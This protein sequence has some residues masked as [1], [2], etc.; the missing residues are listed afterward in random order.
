MPDTSVQLSAELVINEAAFNQAV[1]R[2]NRKPFRIEMEDRFSGPLGRVTGQTDKF[3]RAITAATDRVVAFGAAASAFY[4]V[5]RAISAL[6]RSTIDVEQSLARININLGESQS[7]LKTFERQL[8]SV[9]RNTGQTF[10]AAAAGAEELARQGLG[11][12]ET[13]KRLSDALILSR[14]TGQGVAETVE[15]ITASINS[16]NKEALTSTEVINK[17]AAVDQRF[18]VSA[19]DLADGISR[20]GSTAA[21]AGVQFDELVG[22]ITAV[23]QTTQRGGAVIGNSFKTFFAKLADKTALDNLEAIGIGVRNL[24]GEALPAT[25]ILENL[26]RSYD[27][28]SAAQKKVVNDT[29]GSLYQIN[30]LRAALSDL[31]KEYGVAARATAVA[32]AATDEAVRKNQQLNQTL[33]S[34]LNSVQQ[35]ITQ[36]FSSLGEIR[37]GPFID[38]LVRSF[39]G[40]AQ[41]LAGS[42]AGEQVGQSLGQSILQ[43]ISNV[44]TG[45]GLLLSLQVVAKTILAIGRTV[46]TEL[47]SFIKLGNLKETQAIT[48]NR[49]NTA[50]AKST[51]LEYGQFLAAKGVAE[52][53]A[54]ILRIIERINAEMALATVRQNA[55]RDSFV[56]SI[57]VRSTLFGQ[58][59]SKVPRAADGL[60]PTIRSEQSA[61]ARGVGGATPGSKAVVIPNFAFGGG[62][63][64][65]VVANTSEYI[66][67]NF[68]NGGSA[69]F[70]QDMVKAYGLPMGAKKL[71]KG[72]I[73]NF[74]ALRG[75]RKGSYTLGAGM[76]G[77]VLANK[78]RPDLVFKEF[79]GSNLSESGPG[80][81][82]YEYIVTKALE[83]AGFPVA[84]VYGSL[85]ASKRRGG[86]FKERIFGEEA[87]AGSAKSLSEL[88]KSL[89]FTAY[90]LVPRG[91]PTTANALTTKSGKSVVIDPGLFDLPDSLFDSIRASSRALGFIPN[92]ANPLVS[93][94][95]RE[96]AAGV[97]A[98]D[99]YVSQSPSLRAPGNPAG[100][101]VANTRDEPLGI[102]QGINRVL[103]QGGNP[104]VAGLMNGYVPNF[105]GPLLPNVPFNSNFQEVI[106]SLIGNRKQLRVFTGRGR[107]SRFA[108]EQTLEEIN[109][110][111]Q[112]YKAAVA[113]D[114]K[115]KKAIAQKEIRKLKLTGDSID[116]I[117]TV[118]EAYEKQ[119]RSDTKASLAIQKSI[120][121]NQQKESA[122]PGFV[123][124]SI[125]QKQREDAATTP[126]ITDNS[127]K[128]SATSLAEQEARLLESSTG[129]QRA[130]AEDT[131]RALAA[132][133]P[134]KTI[135]ALNRPITPEQEKENIRKVFRQGVVEDKQA[136]RN[137]EIVA[138]NKRQEELRVRLREEAKRVGGKQLLASQAAQV[139]RAASGLGGIS[140]F[141]FLSSEGRDVKKLKKL[142]VDTE[143]A[144]VKQLLRDR[145][146]RRDSVLGQ[147]AFALSIGASL[148]SGFIPEGKGG[149]ASGRALGA[150]GGAAQ[151]A[152]VG[153][154]LGPVGA[155]VGAGL[156]A[157]IGGLSKLDKSFEELS[158]EVDETVA[159]KAAENDAIQRLISLVE[160]GNQLGPDASAAT[161]RRLNQQKASAS[162]LIGDEDVVKRIL[163]GRFTGDDLEARIEDA[164]RTQ[165]RATLAK[166]AF[167]SQR[168]FGQRAADFVDTADKKVGLLPTI[169]AGGLPSLAKLGRRNVFDEVSQSNLIGGAVSGL[170]TPDKAERFNTKSF[171]TFLNRVQSSGG[172]VSEEDIDT[173]SKAFK[174]LGQQVE[175]T[176]FNAVEFAEGLKKG[177]RGAAEQQKII[178]ENNRQ[179]RQQA[180]LKINLPDASGFFNARR[181]AAVNRASAFGSA[182]ADIIGINSTPLA[183]IGAG[184]DSAL[185]SIDL[186][187]LNQ[188][189]RAIAKFNESI[190]TIQRTSAGGSNPAEEA[191]ARALLTNETAIIGA[192]RDAQKA[193]ARD[194]ATIAEARFRAQYNRDIG[195]GASLEGSD[196][197]RQAFSGLAYRGYNTRTPRLAAQQRDLLVRSNEELDS[198]IG[199]DLNQGRRGRANTLDQQGRLDRVYAEAAKALNARLPGSSYE[200]IRGVNKRGV[201]VALAGI[202]N[203]RAFDQETR[204]RF[205]RYQEGITTLKSYDPNAEPALPDASKEAREALNTIAKDQRDLLSQAESLLQKLA[206][207]DKEIT[208]KI[209]GDI[210]LTSN[211]L[212][213]E[214]LGAI[215]SSLMA[216]LTPIIEA[217]FKNVKNEVDSSKGKPNPPERTIPI[218]K[219]VVPN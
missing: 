121:R 92:F 156:G 32:S 81:L 140:F 43:G 162:S 166:V 106:Q 34:S 72:F 211:V 22:L 13:L 46:G 186:D 4:G 182:R 76:F 212:S 11:S 131:R 219:A 179:Q 57:G 143:N 181:D 33:A 117:N 104:K 80:S 23:Q 155:G 29:V 89:G 6:V 93:A 49:I 2:L 91:L 149:T 35:S 134:R 175:I 119:A 15:T 105:A 196:L 168:T 61:I 75:F 45:P 151:G 51:E 187:A 17:L 16:F 41:D 218:G 137:D 123:P 5:Q 210:Q 87:S 59:K 130:I 25:Q 191:K 202:V 213:P 26:G 122:R 176:A 108:G 58:Y 183:A 24:N 52:Q 184:L 180:R 194:N 152:G 88:A 65:P 55:L 127:R 203:N 19:K 118:F 71:A 82:E 154:L 56:G 107:E 207:A 84:K 114:S 7:G 3:D 199:V 174:T 150:L 27:N 158:A 101:G 204:D 132:A 161:V 97:P 124:E 189:D 205:A 36:V 1:K 86:L 37:L 110:I 50:L 167:G 185:E 209:V 83:K 70:N 54:V 113:E 74:A 77:K 64:G 165:N 98:S 73:P 62:K 20:A 21:D 120:L 128:P 94:I 48:Q 217:R 153:A 216:E 159:K 171:Q 163:G 95:K 90:D 195:R 144:D 47:Q 139:G 164:S 12:V 141:D 169:L 67:P 69:I 99:I 215:R 148:A 172:N 192:N 160:E 138:A 136:R 40:L 66:V 53:Q 28:L 42:N 125:R 214:V 79:S 68:A 78:R 100:L 190:S 116:S 147:R 145:N 193:S 178:E 157:L 126:Y 109:A 133:T 96:R 206:S 146:N 208:A 197:Q 18:A 173:L 30:S 201:D 142:G 102:Y 39:D 115:V 198:I 103:G 170:V 31:G 9:A 188:F 129:V 63:R 135:N 10:K 8:F 112:K 38:S 14:Q 177:I 200:S 111:Y 85:S 44:I 60:V